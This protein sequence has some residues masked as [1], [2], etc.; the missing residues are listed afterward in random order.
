MLA[1]RELESA[2]DA[3][4]ESE[5]RDDLIRARMEYAEAQFADGEPEESGTI[6]RSFREI[7]Y[8]VRDVEAFYTY[9]RRRSNGETYPIPEV[10]ESESDSGDNDADESP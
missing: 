3:F 8:G 2:R 4:V 9:A 10:E 1:Q 7:F 6:W 5:E